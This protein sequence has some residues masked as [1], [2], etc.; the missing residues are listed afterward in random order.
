MLNKNIGFKLKTQSA[1]KK[2]MKDEFSY[3]AL[4]VCMY[5]Y[6]FQ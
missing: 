6:T 1:Y 3:E 5:T 4:Y 2:H